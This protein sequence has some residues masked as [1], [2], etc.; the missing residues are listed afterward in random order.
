MSNKLQGVLAVALLAAANCQLAAQP[1]LRDVP[2][3]AT[4]FPDPFSS[5]SAAAEIRAGV[6]LIFDAAE[7]ELAVVDLARGTRSPLG[8]QGSGPGEYRTPA[9]IFVIRGDSIWVL[10]ATQMRIVVFGPDLKPGTT[11]P[12]MTFDTESG[13]ALTSPIFAD[14]SGNI[15]ASALP[16]EMARGGAN[17][18]M[19]FPDSVS[20][21]RL[22]PRSKSTKSSI[23]R[24][25]FPTSGQPRMEQSGN[26]LKYTFAYPG[27]VASDPWAV[28]PDGRIAIVR[29]ASYSV[30]FIAPGGS[31]SPAVQVPYEPFPVTE[32]D[33]KAEMEDARRRLAEQTKQVQRMLP[34]NVSMT[35]EMLPP[36]SWPDRYPAVAP[37][38]AM[39][40]PDGRLWVKRAVPVRLAR[41]IW[42][43][44]GSDGR[45]LARWRLP[46]KTTIV[47]LG[48]DAIYTARTDT[49]DLRYLQ[50]I[51]LPK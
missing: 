8:R 36:A 43:V 48:R 27:L 42:D 39:A 3:P 25:R 35:F 15:Y 4:E 13:T 41:E 29:G 16:I 23:A 1:T 7:G 37:M 24:V 32:A 46:A 38:G 34:P 33:K 47:A 12:F 2:K 31:R 14:R 20:I 10:D 11:F 28:F 22:D 5:I 6:L 50:R 44:I 21:V 26:T 9:G 45:L 18:A 51:A 19:K 30:E 17:T 49:D 40:A